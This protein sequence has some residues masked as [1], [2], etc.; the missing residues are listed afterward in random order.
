MN[1]EPSV[2]QRQRL[3]EAKIH[4]NRVIRSTMRHDL[5]ERALAEQLAATHA[6]GWSIRDIAKACGVNKSWIARRLGGT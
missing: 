5:R 4:V 3:K 2:E 6:A 1:G